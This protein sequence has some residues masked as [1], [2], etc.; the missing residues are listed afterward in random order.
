[1]SLINCILLFAAAVQ[2]KR[3]VHNW[4]I[5]YLNTSRGLDQ[6]PKR[7]ITVNGKFPLPIVEAEV[8][9][10]LVLNVH[11]S[12]DVPTSLHAH[13]IYQHGTNYYDGVGMFT[14]C[15]IAPGSNFTYEIPLKQSGTHWIHGHTA[16]QN[17]DGLRTPLIIRDPRE[18]WDYDDEYLFVLEDWSPWTMQQS[19]DFLLKPNL[20]GLPLNPPPHGLING[21]NG[22]LT[23]PI[24]FEPGKTYRI[25]LLPMTSFP[26]LE[27]VIDDHDLILYEIDGVRTKP[28]TLKTI[29][30]TPGQRAS[31]LVKAKRSRSNNYSYHVTMNSP[32]TPV[33]AGALPFTF[34]GTVEYDPKAPLAP[35]T[36][37]PSE[38][39]DELTAESLDYLPALQTD[40]SLFMNATWGF[41][42]DVV[43]YD[44]FD[45]VEFRAPKVPT[46]FSA[47]TM[48]D[49]AKNPL[50]YGP[51][52]NARVLKYN[53]VIEIVLFTMASRLFAADTVFLGPFQYVVIRFRADNPGVWLFHCHMD[54]HS[55]NL[56]S[57]FVSAPDVMQRTLR[58]P[59]SGIP[60]SGNVVGRNDY[61]ID[62][63]PIL[64]ALLA[65]PPH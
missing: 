53:E 6:A 31:V 2:A 18:R 63:A 26:N 37:I 20:A 25:R 56:R 41:T 24:K 57:V 46:L 49:K 17:F 3:V 59:Q 13:G 10:L 64:P 55:P 51:Q 62:G 1:M 28:K 39:F 5:T 14:E 38:E 45:Y 21:V 61:N 47:L 52:T 29:R 36:V 22:T 32:G 23:K 12:L 33:L 54:W 40:R 30:V 15:S 44:T 11:N 48:G 19:M 35:T 16:E 43:L 65:S 8:G 34:N 50:V 42:P 9:D 60:T 4:D 7:G 27:F 58:V